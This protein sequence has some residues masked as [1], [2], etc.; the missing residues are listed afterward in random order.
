MIAGSCETARDRIPELALGRLDGAERAEVLFHV[1]GCARCQAVLDDF[2][3]V[4]DLLARSAPE[5]EP[6]PG[7]DRRVLAAMRSG[8][9]VGRRSLRRRALA[10]GAVAAA[11][12]ILSVAVVRLVDAG[13]AVDQ[14]SSP[15]LRTAPMIGGGGLTVGRVVVSSGEPA[16]V[17]VTVDYALPDG[18]YQVE[19]QATTGATDGVVGT[20]AVADGQGSWTGT[21]PLPPIGPTILALLDA[22]GRPVC[23][24]RLEPV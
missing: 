24:A 4:A 23:H 2:N 11:A 15:A 3:G 6:P 14:A 7:F 12:A 16:S 13:R 8:R 18:A 17:V 10:V 22:G 21:V 20:I 1:H 19:L 5:A 9:G